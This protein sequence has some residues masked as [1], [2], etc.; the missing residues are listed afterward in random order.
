MFISTFSHS[1]GC[2]VLIESWRQT[3]WGLYVS[4]ASLAANFNAPSFKL[5]NYKPDVALPCEDVAYSTGVGVY[6]ALR[7]SNTDV[8]I[9]NLISSIAN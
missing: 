2:L 9:A 7:L 6:F 1:E 8:S 5:W 4:D 3:W